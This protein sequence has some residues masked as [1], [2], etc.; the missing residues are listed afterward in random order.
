MIGLTMLIAAA[1]ISTAYSSAADTAR[2]SPVFWNGDDLY[3]HCRH[4][5][6]T[7]CITFVMGASDAIAT[8]A[9]LGAGRRFFCATVNATS[10]QE[11]AIVTQFLADHPDARHQ[12]A[13]SL[14]IAALMQAFPCPK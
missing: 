7:A 6:D 1:S 3:E 8:V 4:P 14:V 2:V 12:V 5:E 13:G 10:E 11:R 9:N